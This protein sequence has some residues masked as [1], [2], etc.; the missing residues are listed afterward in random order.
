[1]LVVEADFASAGQVRGHMQ[2]QTL[3]AQRDEAVARK[4]QTVSSVESALAQVAISQT[5]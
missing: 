2:V 1:M 5:F 4:Q 3:K